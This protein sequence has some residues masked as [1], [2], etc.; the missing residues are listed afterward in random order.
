M[1]PVSFEWDIFIS[2]AHI[3]NL[4]FPDIP[5]GW[6][7]YLQ[8]NLDVRLAQFLGRRPQ[9]WRDPTLAGN[10]VFD[11]T[12]KEKLA[13]TAIFV[14]VLSPRYLESP[15]CRAEVA[16][17]TRFAEE[18]GGIRIGS[19]HRVF[20]VIKTDIPRDA[21]PAGW[22]GLLGY[23]F[24]EKD[25]ASG[26]VREFDHLLI[27][28]QRDKRYWDKLEDLAIDLKETLQFL[29][30]NLHLPP[31]QETSD[32]PPS[33]PVLTET[34]SGSTVYLAETTSDLSAERDSIKRELQQYGH[35]VL[36]DQTLPLYAPTLEQIAREYLRQASLSI[37]LIGMHYGIIPEME[38]SRSS[39]RMQLDLAAERGNDPTFSRVIWMPPGIQSADERQQAL[40]DELQRSSQAGSEL[41]QTKLEDVKT[42][43]HAKL[44]PKPTPAINGHEERGLPSVYLIC[45]KQDC[46]DTKSLE[47]F[48]NDQGITVLPSP[49]EGDESQFAQYHKES[50]QLCDAVL[51]Y[52]GR[53]SDTWAQLKRLDLLKLAGVGRDRPLLAKAFYLSAPTTVPKERFRCPDAIVMKNYQ[54]F[55]GAT[56]A[57]FL[58]QL[59]QSRRAPR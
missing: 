46:D 19:K 1:P 24:Y 41:V 56:L 45:D 51:I 32:Q 44:A 16:D 42:I 22:Q 10:D 6:I 17:F 5:Y 13:K 57:P 2:Y 8:K 20:K 55:D 30:T 35:R 7:D 52:Y 48:L 29:Q 9:M 47:D 39:M 21:H 53:V 43:I 58:A 33:A 36:P 49:F 37:H 38:R 59:Q 28:N 25:P 34:A 14:A 50:L 40:I 27:G 26:R 23:E 54:G 4:H 31:S 12:I 11:E 3:D 15:S 18:Q